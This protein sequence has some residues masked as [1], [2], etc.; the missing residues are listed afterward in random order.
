MTTYTLTVTAQQ[1][2]FIRDA[3]ELLSRIAGG[4]IEEA[5]RLTA[6][7]NICQ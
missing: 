6:T 7:G 4:Q 3:T 1:L 2:A 5:M